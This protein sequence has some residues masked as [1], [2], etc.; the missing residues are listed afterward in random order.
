MLLRTREACVEETKE[1]RV[2]PVGLTWLLLLS[3][4]VGLAIAPSDV[5][6]LDAWAAV[7]ASWRTLVW[8]GDWWRLFTSSVPQ[9]GGPL[10]LLNMVFAFL[11]A[12][13]LEKENGGLRMALVFFVS[14]VVGAAVNVIST[15]T[16]FAG[17]AAGTWGVAAALYV[18]RRFTLGSWAA[19][20]RVPRARAD[21]VLITLSVLALPFFDGWAPIVVASALAGALLPVAWNGGR[22]VK[23]IVASALA[24]CVLASLRPLPIVHDAELDAERVNLATSERRW[25]DVVASSRSDDPTIRWHRVNALLELDRIDEAERALATFGTAITNR[26]QLVARAQYAREDFD[27]AIAT[28]RSIP[29]A[30]SYE[31]GLRLWLQVHSGQALEAEREL[32]AQLQQM[33]DDTQ[34]R[35]LLIDALLLSGQL[36]AALALA[37]ESDRLFPGQFIESRL[38][39]LITLQ[40]HQD[41]HALFEQS[42][43]S[44]AAQRVWRCEFALSTTAAAAIEACKPVEET[45]GNLARELLATARILEGDCTA[46]EKLIAAPFSSW[47]Q[48]LR[49][50]C[51]L[52]RGDD[53]RVHAL[54]RRWPNDASARLLRFALALQQRDG[55]TPKPDVTKAEV[56]N[57]ALLLLLA[58]EVRAAIIPE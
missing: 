5:N 52:R 26:E 10:A 17:N 1:L 23:G 39:A 8:Q 47:E 9:V 14:S 42:N 20:M 22:L 43:L 48:Q 35:F 30:G 27:G 24:V 28:L 13:S 11:W 53:E 46:G 56:E 36:E 31:T 38:T 7:G 16:V 41:A 6:A 51:A 50:V 18:S 44:P 34:S 15:N 32:R 49:I 57:S 21:V 2:H 55:G 54:L 4:I 33:A 3:W 40:R 25:A 45:D 19:V 58:P 12:Q 37:E 29:D